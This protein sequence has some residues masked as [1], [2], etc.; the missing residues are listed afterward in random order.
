MPNCGNPNKVLRY[1]E[2]WAAADEEMAALGA[3]LM[4]PGHGEPIHGGEQIRTGLLEQAEFLHAVVDQT[5]EGLNQGLRH[6]QIV[7]SIHVP[8]HLAGLEHLQP[9]YDRP[10]FIARNVIRR[11]G[12][13]FDGYAA[14]LLPASG[15]EIGAEVA[16]LAGGVD[17]L[18]TRARTLAATNLPLA[19]HLA[20]WAY[21]AAPDDD[22]ARQCVVDLFTERADA[23]PSLMSKGVYRHLVRRADGSY[24]PARELGP[25]PPRPSA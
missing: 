15:E 6:D 17:A 9:T 4:L 13:W 20:E 10:E 16:A 18:V 7:R 1:P 21:L 24:D 3:E 22:A 5:L 11:Y 25:N 12:G 2:E 14:D 23:D 8:E 19:C